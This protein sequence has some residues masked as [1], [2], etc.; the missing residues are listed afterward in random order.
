MYL[1][2]F[3]L[4]ACAVFIGWHVI[5][6]GT[7]ELYAKRLEAGDDRVVDRLLTF[8]PN[9]PEGLLAAALRS[10]TDQPDET[11]QL[12]ARAYNA[13]PAS[14][15]PLIV[16]A[17]VATENDQTQRADQLMEAAAALAPVTPRVLKEAAA[18]W[19]NRGQP[20]RAVVYLST[21][22]EADKALS[23]ELFPALF[24]L[25][26]D[27]QASGL[28][29]PFAAR[30][31]TWWARFFQQFAS[32][33]EDLD[34]L[35]RLYRLR[36]RSSTAPLTPEERAAYVGRLQKEGDVSEAY[37]VWASGLSQPQRKALGLLFNGQFELPLS[38][39]GFGWNT[40]RNAH[41]TAKVLTT[42]GT[43][44]NRALR[45]RFRAHEQ[46]FQHLVQP[47]FLDPGTYRLTGRVR[48]ERF[49]S[50]GGLRWEVRCLAPERRILA[51]G[52]PFLSAPDWTP[53]AMD[54][55]V[56]QRCEQTEL[57]LVS[58]GRRPFELRIDGDIWFDDLRIVR[59]QTDDSA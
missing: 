53:F 10:D 15:W 34:A 19:A 23:K 27:P 14:P 52:V 6:L 59:T 7:A 48:T 9:H 47:L 21:A 44:A 25:A 39:G 3:A 1:W 13:N 2:R 11:L 8:A 50:D 49:E 22:L 12:L 32:R 37:V 24:K 57:R 42:A 18:Y 54:F 58:A 46:R 20:Q 30:P 35:R 31:P 36:S 55:E 38:E 51:Q 26:E 17:G 41:A 43:S 56:P 28:L 4:A 16:A 33:A 45:L 40:L 29:E 5:A